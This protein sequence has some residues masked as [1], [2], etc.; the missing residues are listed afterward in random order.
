MLSHVLAAIQVD[1]Q[2]DVWSIITALA[3]AVAAI[4]TVGAV[5]TALFL[6]PWQAKQSRPKLTLSPEVTGLWTTSYRTPEADK[7][8]EPH[9]GPVLLIS[10]ERGKDTAHGV[11]VLL[12]VYERP[13]Q[14]DPAVEP[15]T[16]RRFAD[17]ALN[18]SDNDGYSGTRSANVGPGATRRVYLTRIGDPTVLFKSWY[19]EERAVPPGIMNNGPQFLK[20]C[21]AWATHPARQDELVWLVSSTP[22]WVE[23]MVVGDNFDALTYRGRIQVYIIDNDSDPKRQSRS[24]AV[25][26][27]LPLAPATR[28]LDE[29]PPWS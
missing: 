22:Y 16:I 1:V 3:A 25:K 15:L 23:M 29:K 24:V 27:I 11:E 19:P 8:S 20:F 21:G 5:I 10:N 26:W 2:S 18:Y 7:P 6:P 4:G 13:D 17:R 12:T 14:N 28:K 9:D